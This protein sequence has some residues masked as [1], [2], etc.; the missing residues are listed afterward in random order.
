MSTRVVLPVWQGAASS[1]AT[2]VQVGNLRI[3]AA[4]LKQLLTAG[5]D[6]LGLVVITLTF[7]D[8]RSPGERRAEATRRLLAALRSLVR[9]TDRVF[10]L[11]QRGY[12]VLPNC[13]ERERVAVEERLWWALCSRVSSLHACELADLTALAVGGRTI[14]RTESQNLLSVLREAASAQRVLTAPFG[15]T[16]CPSDA[17]EA[18]GATRPSAPGARYDPLSRQALSRNQPQKHERDWSPLSSELSEEFLAEARRLGIPYLAPLPRRVPASVRQ[19]IS[20]HLAHELHCCPIGRARKTLTVALA[21]G[22]NHQAI[23]ERLRRETGLQIFPVLTPPH[24]L[25]QAL[26]RLSASSSKRR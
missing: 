19:A 8:Q 9:K 2:Y 7:A 4:E 3:L 13:S 24:E 26:E 1:G 18:G 22:S 14:E 23:L 17:G 21:D 6:R 12:V 15:S 16:R 20:P 10:I 11:S 25:Q 5:I